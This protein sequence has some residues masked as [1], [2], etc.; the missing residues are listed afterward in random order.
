MRTAMLTSPGLVFTVM[1]AAFWFG[2]WSA[3]AENWPKFRGWRGD[4]TSGESNVPRRWGTEENILWKTPIPGEGHSSPIVWGTNVFVTSAIRETG[5]RVLLRLETRRGAVLWQRVVATSEIEPMHRENSAA[6]STPVTD[7]TAV[8]TSFQVGDRV[9]LRCFD[10][11]GRQVWAAQPLR[12]QGEH[13]YSHSPILH[14]QCLLLDCRQ[15]G[16]AAVLALDRKTGHIRWRAQPAARRISHVP[17][18]LIQ[19][20]GRVQLVVCGSGEIRSYHPETGAP[21]WW[22]R[23]PS[24][25]AVSGLAYGDGMIFATAGYP[26]RTR[27]AVRASGVGDVTTT[28]IAWTHR[29]QVTYVPSPVFHDHHLYTVTD[30][31]LLFCFAARTGEPVW[32]HRLGGRFRSSLVMADEHIYATDDNGATTVFEATPKAFRAVATNRLGEPCYATPAISGGCIFLR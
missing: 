10:Y 24:D 2:A 32:E 9:D 18:L 23:S 20:R 5:Q 30:D 29:R 21:L 6:S 17:P 28:H 7:G 8:F 4:G 1:A 16:E 3:E 26:T 27:M 12:Y 22:C 31:G 13:G 11:Q 14:G 19:D 15:E 25:V